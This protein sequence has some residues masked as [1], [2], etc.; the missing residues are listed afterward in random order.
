MIKNLKNVN[1]L[2]ERLKTYGLKLFLKKFLD[3]IK[4]KYVTI[5]LLPFI[6]FSFK[7]FKPKSINHA[8]NFAFKVYKGFIRPSQIKE[9]IIE[10]LKIYK[11]QKPKIILKLVQPLVEL[12]FYF[13]N[14]HLLMLK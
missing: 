8:V 12:Y 3:K 7:R 6:Y 10:L 4:R 2:L 11:K 5:F 1:F 13:V 9:E 14:W